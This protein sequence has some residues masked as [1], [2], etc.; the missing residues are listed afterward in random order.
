MLRARLAAD[1]GEMW[2]RAMDVQSWRMKGLVGVAGVVDPMVVEVCPD[3]A[4]HVV[5]IPT[6]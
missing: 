1:G 6:E 5:V 2:R 4:W 3:T